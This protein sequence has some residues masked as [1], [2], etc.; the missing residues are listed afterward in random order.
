MKSRTMVV[1]PRLKLP[2]QLQE[3]FTRDNPR[4]PSLW[5]SGGG[6]IRALLDIENSGVWRGDW[7][8]YCTLNGFETLFA[9]TSLQ[10]ERVSHAYEQTYRL[11]R[12]HTLPLHVFVGDHFSHPTEVFRFFDISICQVAISC[13]SIAF[14]RLAYQ[15]LVRGEFQ[16]IRGLEI[17]DRSEFIAKYRSRGFEYLGPVR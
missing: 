15:H 13:G 3:I 2:K 6:A 7:D 11:Y 5:L 12:E 16:F 10:L 17:P 4:S 8:L 14:G 9:P 1:D